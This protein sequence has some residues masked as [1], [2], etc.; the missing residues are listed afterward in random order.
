[1]IGRGL[2]MEIIGVVLGTMVGLV[3]GV[4][5]KKNQK[6]DSVEPTDPEQQ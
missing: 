1:M 2:G 4:L 5:Y 3:G 6:Q